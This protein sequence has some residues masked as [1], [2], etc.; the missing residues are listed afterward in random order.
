MAVHHV[1]PGFLEDTEAASPVSASRVERS[2]TGIAVC[3][4]DGR[5]ANGLAHGHRRIG[6]SG[7]TIPGTVGAVLSGESHLSTDRRRVADPHR[8]GDVSHLAGSRATA[9]DPAPGTW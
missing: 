3:P 2:G 5:H 1:V 9:G 7:G 6:E 4:I 8:D